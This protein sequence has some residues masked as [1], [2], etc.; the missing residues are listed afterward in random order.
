MLGRMKEK[1]L[2]CE[3][4]FWKCCCFSVFIVKLLEG[5]T[6]FVEDDLLQQS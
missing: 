2:S 5:D 3:E 4:S 1:K 6:V